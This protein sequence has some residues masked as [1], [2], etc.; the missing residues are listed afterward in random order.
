MFK[1]RRFLKPY[2]RQ[3]VVGSFAKLI[4][5]FLELLLPLFMARI[6]DVGVRNGNVSYVWKMGLFMLGVIL[7]GLGSALLC[8]YFAS[9]TA[10]GVGNSIRI[11]LMHKISGLRCV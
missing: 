6:I 4:E 11:E 10:H 9:V 8:Q 7:L 3:A 5:A 2:W 1:L